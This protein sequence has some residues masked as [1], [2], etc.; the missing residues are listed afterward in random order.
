MK[1]SALSMILLLCLPQAGRLAVLPPPTSADEFKIV[2]VEIAKLD[3]LKE[4]LVAE[5]RH[6]STKMA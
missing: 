4:K 1:V 2:K 6:P 3:E 5:L